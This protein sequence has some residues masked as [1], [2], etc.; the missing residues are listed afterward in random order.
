MKRDYSN[1]AFER[2]ADDIIIHCRTLE[3]AVQIL[4]SVEKRLKE[5][6][7]ELNPD[8]TK[9]VYC[10]KDGRNEENDEIKF[11]FLGFTFRPRQAKTRKGELFLN[12]LPAIANKSCTKI[13]R[14]IR[15]WK[16]HRQ[17]S[18]TISEI[19][20][21]YNAII[22]GWINYYGRFYKSAMYNSLRNIDKYLIRWL[23]KKYKRL[24]GSFRKASNLLT[25]IK[26]GKPDLFVHWR[27]V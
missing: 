25:R 16:I 21:E 20:E 26:K 18:R 11:D 2:Y 8:K 22:R 10:K 14:A 19:A 3:E 9:I 4:K 13:N 27:Y 17:T 5:W 23:V 15:N 12:F 1:L 7:L 24:K 6:S